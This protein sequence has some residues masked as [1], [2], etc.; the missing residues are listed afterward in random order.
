MLHRAP[1]V[2][3]KNHASLSKC[4]LCRLGLPTWL[5]FIS[6][7]SIATN[8]PKFFE[9]EVIWFSIHL[10]ITIDSDPQRSIVD[11]IFLEVLPMITNVELVPCWIFR[12]VFSAGS[13]NFLSE[14]SLRI[15]FEVDGSDYRLTEMAANKV[16]LYLKDMSMWFVKVK[17][18]I[19]F[20]KVYLMWSNYWDQIILNGL[21][22]ITSL[23]YFN[24]RC[25]C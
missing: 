13:L 20:K 7:L 4:F 16:Y 9:F 3:K 19:W 14:P 17:V 11:C 24:S 5:V 23:I 8:I 12:K 25:V 2:T 10:K 18:K 1:E 21:V 15:S 6:L 22:P